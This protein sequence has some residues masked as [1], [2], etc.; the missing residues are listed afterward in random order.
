LAG[1]LVIKL[2]ALGDFIQ[3]CGPFKAIRGHHSGEK[4]TLLTTK[5]FVSIATASNYFDN[6]W[7][8]E[9]P[10]LLQLGAWFRLRQQLKSGYFSRVYDLQTSDRTALYYR[11]FGTLSGL[12]WSG[13]ARN[14]SHPHGNPRRDYMHTLDRQSEQLWDAGITCVPAPE[15]NWLRSDI[16]KFKL[17][18]RYA[19][20]VPGGSA[21]RANKQWPIHQFK[22]LAR[23]LTVRGLRVV[24]IGQASEAVI[25][26]EVADTLDG[27]ISLAGATTLAEVAALGRSAMVSIGNDT[28]PMHILA[29]GKRPTFVLFGGGSD[30]ALCAP[31]GENVR[32]LISSDHGP[33][34][35]LS[36]EQ[37][38]A[39]VESTVGSA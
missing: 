17:S 14:C 19:L 8:D 21:R 37:V 1:I 2:G 20:L 28:G 10:S 32:C 15:L 7:I 11:L 29:A 13:I 31:R 35:D 33:I 3:A 39:A 6:V 22:Q 4:I 27:V 25:H 26:S 36:V 38:W 12:E 18:G 5:P 23:K 16:D 9:C 34:E 30:P 24:L